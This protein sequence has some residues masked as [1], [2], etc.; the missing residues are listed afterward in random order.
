MDPTSAPISSLLLVAIVLLIAGHTLYL[1]R[2]GR[3]L[4]LDPLNAFWGGV[5]VVYIIQPIQ[6]G[7]VTSSWH[8]PGILQATLAWALLA[9]GCVVLGYEAS[10]GLKWGKALPH[11]PTRLNPGRVTMAGCGMIA[12]SLVGYIYLIGTAGGFWTWLAT[13][14]GGTNWAVVNSY[15]ATLIY[16]LPVGISL[17]LF[18]V[19]LW[20]TPAWAATIVWCLEGLFILWCAYIGSRSQVIAG[21]MTM[22]A[23]Y[24]LPRRS[25]PPVWLMAT[26]FLGLLLVVSFMASYRSYFANLS[27]NFEEMDFGEVEQRVLPEFLGGDA[28]LQ[29]REVAGGQDFNCVMS[30]IDLV[31]QEV[32][33]NYGS[34]LLE[35]VTR[36]I[37]RSV[38]PDKVYP[39]YEA[40]TPICEKARL[41]SWIVP[42][43]Q[44]LILAGPAF[45]FVGHW[46]AVGGPF[47]LVAAGFLTG[48]MFRM[49]R[50][51]YQRTAG[52]QGDKILYLFL[53]PIGF[54]EAA[55]TP[56]FWIFGI[57][58]FLVPIVALLFICREASAP[59]TLL[60]DRRPSSHH[61]LG[62]V[63]SRPMLMNGFYRA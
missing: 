25:N 2:R 46:F 37:P 9:F 31:P 30:V 24:Y 52:S 40:F 10:W 39:H 28:K 47:A 62:V 13:P 36:L 6:F 16:L 54:G 61:R 53:M 49:I 22:L 35:F 44:R 43:S 60:G 34:C 5:V 14:R 58:V 27:F 41:S 18:R 50:T 38:W 26:C 42:T 12:L 23:V 57:G 56:M 11:M 17:L 45:T 59:T 32:D 63:R 33:F 7:D 48:C 51:I 20:R 19:N 3:W 15:I 55:A 8:S 29:K 4:A 1:M 21:V